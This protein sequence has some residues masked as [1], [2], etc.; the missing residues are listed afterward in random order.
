MRNGALL[1]Y[2]KNKGYNNIEGIDICDEQVKWCRNNICKN[3]KNRRPFGFF[4][5]SGESAFDLVIMN[6][7]IEHLPKSEIVDILTGVRKS[8]KPG[9]SLICRLPNMSN[10]FG[11][12]LLYN[13]FTH[14]AGFTENSVRQLLNLSG[15]NDIVISG[16]KTRVNCLWKKPL[17]YLFSLISNTFITLALK[18]I[19]M[20]G[21]KQPRIMNTFLI[22]AARE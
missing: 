11:V 10:I 6:D 9:G 19:Y 4:T 1:L 2:L 14:E 20:P 21:S 15:F 18:Y 13:D 17:F 12:Y 8:L 3:V 22:A 5:H 16:N 7:L